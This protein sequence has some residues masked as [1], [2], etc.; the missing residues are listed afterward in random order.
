MCVCVWCIY[1]CVVY[2][3]VHIYMGIYVVYK[4]G[5][6]HMEYCLV[7]VLVVLGI[8]PESHIW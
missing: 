2:V 7:F 3:C 6:Y 4:Y 5:L 1:V 8:K